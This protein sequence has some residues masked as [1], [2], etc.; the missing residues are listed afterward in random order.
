MP[1]R[2]LCYKPQSVSQRQKTF[3]SPWF[4]WDDS[5]EVCVCTP[6]DALST[7]LDSPIFAYDHMPNPDTEPMPTIW[8]Q[9]TTKNV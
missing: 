8:P 7:G 9:S 6:R 2:R 1:H 4:H 3:T 5:P